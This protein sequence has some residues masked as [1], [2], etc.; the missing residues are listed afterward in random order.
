VWQG[1][2][3]MLGRGLVRLRMEAESWRHNLASAGRLSQ[4]R[5]HGCPAGAAARKQSAE[6]E[7]GEEAA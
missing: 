4:G 7:L 2:L 5:L 6:A 1:S 3:G